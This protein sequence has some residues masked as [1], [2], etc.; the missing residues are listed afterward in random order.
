MLKTKVLSNKQTILVIERISDLME[1]LY[2]LK[3]EDNTFPGMSN[4]FLEVLSPIPSYYH[5]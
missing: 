4:K 3:N 5:A 1:V 2:I